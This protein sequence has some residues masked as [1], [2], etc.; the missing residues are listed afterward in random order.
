MNCRPPL[1][2]SVLRQSSKTAR[3]FPWN[4]PVVRQEVG[5]V[6]AENPRSKFL[7]EFGLPESAM[8]NSLAAQRHR[9]ALSVAG[10]ACGAGDDGPALAAGRRSMDWAGVCFLGCITALGGGTLRDLFSAIIRS[11]GCEKPLYLGLTALARSSPFRSRAS[12][13]R[14]QRPFS[15]WTPS[16]SWSSP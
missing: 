5:S 14:L 6:H 16:G 7:R 4:W 15:C 1:A 8:W 10:C 11:P 12:V 9:V 13:H 3:R 2:R